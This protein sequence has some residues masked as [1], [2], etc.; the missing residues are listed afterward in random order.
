M[1]GQFCALS[2]NPLLLLT[3]YLTNIFLWNIIFN[4]RVKTMFMNTITGEY[5]GK[6]TVEPEP[7]KEFEEVSK[8]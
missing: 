7:S 4:K 6:E 3:F 1:F 5:Y 8:R 2:Y